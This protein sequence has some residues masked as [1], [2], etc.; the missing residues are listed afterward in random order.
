MAIEFVDQSIDEIWEQITRLMNE[1]P[2]PHQDSE[3]VYQFDLS[4]E[5]S[6]TYQL[7]LNKGKVSVEQGSPYSSECRLIMDFNEFKQL[8][9][10]QL[11]STMAYMMGKIKVDGSLGL[12]LKLETLLKKYKEFSC[13][14]QGA[15]NGESYRH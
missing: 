4:G 2:E 14:S 7:I 10:G 6:G 11:N 1:H 13:E 3:C 12:A 5:M 8:L 9:F 15:S